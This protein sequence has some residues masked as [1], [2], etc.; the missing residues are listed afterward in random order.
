MAGGVFD[1]PESSEIARKHGASE[2]Q[3]SLVWLLSK[4]NVYPI[5][6]STSASHLRANLEAS[7]LDLD[8]DVTRIDGIDRE[9][10]LVDPN[11]A[12]WNQ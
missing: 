8:E 10:R 11:G 6:K 2:A 3:V 7:D 5:P 1:V 4:P 9:R 12:P